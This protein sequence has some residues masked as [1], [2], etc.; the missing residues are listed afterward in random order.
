MFATRPYPTNAYSNVQIETSIQGADRH[1][2]ISLLLDDALSAM[3]SVVN[4]IERD[5]AG[6][7]RCRRHRRRGPARR[8]RP[9]GRQP[10]RGDAAQPVF[11]HRRQ[12]DSSQRRQRLHMLREC[13]NLLVPVREAWV[14][15]R[16]QRIAA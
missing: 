15:I 12:A 11:V 10:G 14:A 13:S 4:A 16:P 6:A 3:A 5:D 1:Q 2:L 9:P 7:K 8:A